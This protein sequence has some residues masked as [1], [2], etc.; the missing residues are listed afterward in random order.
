MLR[1]YYGPDT[2]S[3]SEAI[4]ELKAEL[5]SDGM[6]S[7]NTSQFEGADLDLAALLSTC[8]TVPFLSAHRLVIVNNL[9]GQTQPRRTRQRAPRRASEGA[10]PSRGEEL[11]DYIPRMPSTTTLLLLEGALRPD[12]ALLQTLSPLAQTR[13]F[14][15]L[16]GQQL[17]R[18]ISARA[19][20]L[21]S[22]IEPRAAVLLADSL[23]GDLWML[24]GE[25]E[26]LSLY[27]TGRTIAEADV[28]SMVSAT[29][30]SNVFAMVD[31]II[32][33]RTGE[34]LHQLRLLLN[35]GAAPAYVIAM[36]ARQYRQLII[37]QDLA[38]T[39][40]PA[41]AMALAAEIRS[42]AAARRTAQEARR[43]GHALL[44]EAYERIL[45]AD[46]AIKRGR[47]EESLAVELMV[48]DLARMQALSRRPVPAR[49]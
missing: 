3:R 6:L 4:V 29:Q 27:A 35:E 47:T 26:K 16:Q 36:V 11:A 34:A 9:L 41:P 20:K 45:V 30:E 44:Q 21:N 42:E 28:R 49:T 22:Q 46:L 8:D 38:S 40:E 17:L 14:P 10:E 37:L 12:N 48:S 1:I 39:N 18:W 2:Y 15:Q 32:A 25:I 19:S 5:D 24:A 23:G 33:G 43:L 31:A 7:A 13:A